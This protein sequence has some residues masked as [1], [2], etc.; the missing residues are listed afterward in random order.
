MPVHTESDGKGGLQA[1]TVSREKDNKDK[2]ESTTSSGAH[3]AHQANLG[4][5]IPDDLPK[6]ESKEDLKK[7][8]EALNK[9]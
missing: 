5:A 8:M 9:D 2:E 6:A 7:R 3:A 4:P 1:K